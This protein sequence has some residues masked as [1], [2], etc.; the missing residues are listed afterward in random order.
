MELMMAIGYL[1]LALVLGSLVA[2]IAEKLKI[3]DIPLLLLLGLIIGPFLQII[4][5]DSAMEIFEYAGPI[6]L[7]FILLGGAFTMRISL[8]KRVIKTVVR[9]DTITFL[10]TLLIS[11]FIFNMVLNLPYTSPV[12]YLFGAITAAT[13]P[14]TLIPVFS[15]VRTNPEVAITLEAESIFN[16]PLGIV[17]TSVILGLF[18]LF[19]SSNPLIDLITLAGGAIVVGLLLAKIY[20]KIIIH[21]DFHEYVAPLVLGGAMLLLYVGDDLLPSIC[22][23]GFSG[24]MAVAIMGLYLGDALFRADDIDYK[25]IVSFCDDLSLLA[26]VFIFVFLGA[27]IKL[28]MLENY[29]IPGLLVALGSIFLA[30]PLGV[31][32]GLIGSKHSFKEK[33]YFALEGPRGVVP[34]AL[35]VTVGIEILK[36]ADKI[37]ASITKYITPTDIAG[38]IIIGTFM[39]ILLSVILEASWAGML[40]LKLLGEYKPKYKEESH[41]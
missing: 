2:K 5:S 28:S 11:G 25:Y 19:S 16:D 41:H 40:A 14:A 10:I 17:S 21:C 6:G 29:F 37:P 27:C 12:G 35:A 8:L 26:R 4:P 24:Y 33:L 31:F 7:I 9:L 15:R 1:G 3:P 34:A 20:E 39:T 38:T 18:G 22:G 13:D 23:Y 30:R 32:L 36:N